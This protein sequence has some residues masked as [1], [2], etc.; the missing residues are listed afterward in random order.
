MRQ[1]GTD[2]FRSENAEYGR[3]LSKLRERFGI[4]YLKTVRLDDDCGG[5][6]RTAIWG[7]KPTS[8]EGGLLAYECPAI[9]MGLDL[10]YPV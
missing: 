9:T 1:K 8:C 2:V 10:S 5:R 7:I 3:V 4:V 6:T